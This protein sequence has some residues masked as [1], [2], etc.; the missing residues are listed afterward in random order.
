MYADDSH[1]TAPGLTTNSPSPWVAYKEII[2]NYVALKGASSDQDHLF[3]CPADTF[4]FPDFSAP[5]LS[6][7]HH[8]P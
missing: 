3:A 7:R 8:R 2:K 1:G 6:R 4:Y 5:R